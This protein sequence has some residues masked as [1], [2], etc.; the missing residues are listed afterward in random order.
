MNLYPQTEGNYNFFVYA[1]SISGKL[2]TMPVQLTVECVIDSQ[3]IE[4]PG[5]YLLKVKK[6]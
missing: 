1:I 6:N 3:T 2:I 4:A 5:E